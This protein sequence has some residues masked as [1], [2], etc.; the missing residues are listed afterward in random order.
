MME[1]EVDPLIIAA[2]GSETRVRTLATLAG[3]SRPITVYRVGKTGGIP[4]PKAYREVER[5]ERAGVV[6]RAKKGVELIDPD[7]RDLF[8]KRV[9]ILWSEDQRRLES[10]RA[11]RGA[12]VG[13]ED[14]SWFEPSRY[15]PNPKVAARYAREF[16]R[17]PEK[18][19]S[20]KTGWR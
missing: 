14:D 20:R 13:A 11:A 9:R 1:L 2:F 5:L 19:P 15:T 18:G 17:P 3:A 7:L 6:R 10:A 4:L 16:R 12:K 8:R